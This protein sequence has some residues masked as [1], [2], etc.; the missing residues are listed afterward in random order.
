MQLVFMLSQFT[1]NSYMYLCARAVD[2]TYI[3]VHTVASARHK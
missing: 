3:T 1:V 2:Y